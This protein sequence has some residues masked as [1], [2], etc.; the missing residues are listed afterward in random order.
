MRAAVGG[1]L[2]PGEAEL[3]LE[4]LA[5]RLDDTSDAVRI[6]ACAAAAAALQPSAPAISATAGDG[7]AAL[8]VLHMDDAN[9]GQSQPFPYPTL[10]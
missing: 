10:W 1:A 8:A 9:P 4:E 2:P 7:L 5:K 3:C 6:A